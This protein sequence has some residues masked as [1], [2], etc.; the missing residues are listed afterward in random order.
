MSFITMNWV[1]RVVFCLFCVFNES[2]EEKEL[3]RH[4]WYVRE[5][6]GRG[7]GISRSIAEGSAFTLI[8][9][10]K[11]RINTLHFEIPLFLQQ[12]FS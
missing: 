4:F 1:K 2:F 9:K 7:E 8:K 3:W 12:L 10:N 6:D 5:A 11:L